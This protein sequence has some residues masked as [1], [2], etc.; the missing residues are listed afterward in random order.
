MGNSNSVDNTKKE[1]LLIQEID[2]I[3]TNYITTQNFTDMERLADMDYCNNL[4]IM[5][6]DIIASKL[7]DLNVQY[8]SQ[9]LK[10]GIEVNEM[11]TSNILYVN[12]TNLD[13]IDIKNPT[14]KK[15]LCIGIAKFYVKIAHLFSAIVSTVNP[16]YVYKDSYGNTVETNLLNKKDLPKNANVNIKKMN[17]CSKRLEALIHN[18]DFDKSKDAKVTIH[19][20]FCDI[21]YDKVRNKDRNLYQEPGIPELEKLYYDEYDY[22][23]GGFSRM[24]DKM[25]LIYEKDV[26]TFYKAFTG[27]D[28][29][30]KFNNT[31]SIKKF[32]DIMLRDFHKS[33]GC[34]PNGTYTNAYTATLKNK[35]FSSYAQHLKTMMQTTTNNQD[36]LLGILKELFSTIVN[37]ETN[38]REII[39]NPKLTEERLQGLVHDT[40]SIIVKLYINCET[41][42][43]KGLELFQAIVEKQIMETSQEQI[44]QLQNTL[45]SSLADVDI[46]NTSPPVSLDE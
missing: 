45:Q 18:E 29:L 8:L 1:G 5:T 36:K 17:I 14:E 12:K 24:S 16:V 43:V 20:I 27:D 9:R 23:E 21:N 40:R 44:Q 30:P 39:I 41:D 35:L 4:V 10:N 25:R 2:F 42:F 6:A 3:A 32:S 11:T 28:S 13:N 26:E 46:D 31:S 15:R 33:K 38:R 34:A 37:T 19:P 7:N 22:E